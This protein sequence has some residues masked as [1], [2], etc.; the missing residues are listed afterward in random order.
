MANAIIT[1]WVG[2]MHGRPHWSKYW[3]TAEPKINVK[4]LYPVG[5][6]DTFNALRRRLDPDAMFVNKFLKD[7][8]LFG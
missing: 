2:E 6:L 1:A 4:A 3:H 8:G 7:Q 5:N